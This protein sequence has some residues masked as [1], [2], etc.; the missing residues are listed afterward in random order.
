MDLNPYKSPQPVASPPI[1]KWSWWPLVDWYV[2]LGV[3]A[4]GLLGSFV[5]V[6][7]LYPVLMKMALW[8]AER[9]SLPHL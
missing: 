8:L 5:A 3:T 9:W 2:D 6:G 1:R 7:V 4:A